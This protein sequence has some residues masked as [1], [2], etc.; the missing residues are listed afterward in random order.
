MLSDNGNKKLKILFLS[1]W[2]PTKY[3]SMLGLFV[4]IH[5]KA[6]SKFC[7]V[8][9]IYM[10]ADQTLKKNE[11]LIKSATDAGF[12]EILVYYKKATCAIPFLSQ[13]IKAHRL[14]KAFSKGYGFLL[15]DSGAPDLVHVNILT[16]AA[17]PAFRLKRKCNIPYIIT[18]H[19]SRYLPSV[20]TFRGCVRKWLTKWIV[21]KADAVTTVNE[22]LKDAMIRHKLKNEHYSIVPNVVDTD[23]FK[24]MPMQDRSIKTFIHISCFEDKSKNISGIIRAVARLSEERTDF[25]V[26]LV[27]DGADFNS[28]KQLS[29]RY[30]LTDRIIFFKG[31]LENEALNDMV[32]QSDATILF[33]NYETFG[34]VLFESMACGVPVI[35]TKTGLIRNIYQSEMGFLVD[36]GD[37]DQLVNAM[38]A[39]LDGH[40]VTDREKLRSFVSE[41]YSAEAVGKMF[42]DIYQNVLDKNNR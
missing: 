34:I 14:L 12:R 24:I 18:E 9:V 13:L 2:Y 32:N 23:L 37:E 29:D 42:Y 21:R 25:R 8:S 20:N 30:N 31:L 39:F 7:D 26:F 28:M 41:K 10:H 19:W 36:V 33:S 6:V 38:K 3:D 15:K 22:D 1:A 11:Y 5:A 4:K 17:I 40:F 16:R 27:G 35:S